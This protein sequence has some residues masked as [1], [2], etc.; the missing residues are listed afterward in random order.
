MINFLW[1][2][3]INNFINFTLGYDLYYMYLVTILIKNFLVNNI[4]KN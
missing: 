3:K 2:F 1:K 4:I